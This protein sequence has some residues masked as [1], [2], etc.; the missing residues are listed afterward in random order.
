[1]GA[2]GLP[3]IEEGLAR[4]EEEAQDIA[5]RIGYPVVVKGVAADLTHK[6]DAG[7][8]RVNLGRCGGRATGLP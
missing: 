6:S 3:L 7:A 8:V 5:E 2:F 4:T 1:M